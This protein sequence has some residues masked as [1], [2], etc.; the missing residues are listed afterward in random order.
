[1][2]QR[3][4]GRY[5]ILQSLGSGTFGKT[6]L[7]KDSHL[8]GSPL[9]VV[10]QLKPELRNE[11]DLEIARRLFNTEAEVIHQLGS[12]PQIPQLFAYFEQDQEFYL[13]QEFID[14]Q[15]LDT[16]L[17]AG[18]KQDESYVIPLLK[19]L[20]GILSYVHQNNVIH[21]D[22]KPS[23]VI[24]RK[25]GQLVLIDFGAVKQI[26]TI[27]GK[28]SGTMLSTVMIGTPGY[29]PSEQSAG[30]PRFSSDVYAVGMMA[31]QALTGISPHEL[32]ED[33]KTGEINWQHLAQV[34]DD[35]AD[36]LTKMVRYD[37]RERYPS[38]IEVL[39][40]INGLEK[41]PFQATEPFFK[42]DQKSEETKVSQKFQSKASK[43]GL[44]DLFSP[45]EFSRKIDDFFGGFIPQNSIGF[46]E[47][48][49]AYDSILNITPKDYYTW[50]KRGIELEKLGRYQE[51]IT[52]FNQVLK[53]QPNYYQAWFHK[54]N[55]YLILESYEEAI[56]SYN[57]VLEIN[58]DFQ[59]A[60][61]NRKIAMDELRR[62][63]FR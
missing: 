13:V 17:T 62:Q 47:F 53:L 48:V 8:P 35:L 30:K 29:M 51:A 36:I 50:Y 43:K 33:H 52:S 15:D 54:G 26:G 21:R 41:E 60:I 16:E 22:I 42:I 25:T 31:I 14:G 6:F 12:H 1:M 20:L 28:P 37:W 58:P 61:N 56:R 4:G 27:M 3:L 63:R 38:A 39:E 34:N 23:N 49:S 45:G 9:C 19:D 10:K 5:E 7:A 44:E 46:E 32:P 2:T 24:R 59:E 40:A 57:K 18:T 55:I 11:A